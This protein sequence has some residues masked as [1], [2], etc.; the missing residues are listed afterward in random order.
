MKRAIVLYPKFN[1]LE[2]IQSKRQKFDP[3]ANYIAPHIT[4]VFPFESDLSTQEIGEH[5]RRA[6]KGVNR[7]PIR[8]GGFTGDQ[9]DGYLFLKVKQGNDNIIDLH[10]RLYSGALEPFLFR[11]ILYCPHL[12]VGKVEDL[13]AFEDALVELDGIATIFEC[14]ISQVF[15]ENIDSHEQSTVE[16]AIDLE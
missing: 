2:E 5:V 9:P 7:F 10:D 15:V 13:T 11:K 8:L 12:T 1:G 6:I 16:L 14:E 4:L 3:L